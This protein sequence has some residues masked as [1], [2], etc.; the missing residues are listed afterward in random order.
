[1]VLLAKCR[2]RCGDERFTEGENARLANTKRLPSRATF[3][4]MGNAYHQE[5]L[6]L[7]AA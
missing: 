4:E 6:R 5:A 7:G 2:R 3:R 1:M